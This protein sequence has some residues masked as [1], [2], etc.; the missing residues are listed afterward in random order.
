MLTS[1]FNLAYR[2]ILKNKFY[3]LVNVLS[4][5]VA[6][7]IAIIAYWV[8]QYNQ[9]F[10][11]Y[12]EDGNQILR[13]HQE[14]VDTTKKDTPTIPL[15]Q[16]DKFEYFAKDSSFLSRYQLHYG[17]ASSQ[18]T[19]NNSIIAAVDPTFFD[20]FSFD[21]V[22]PPLSSQ[23]RP[24]WI[25]LSRPMAEKM[26]GTDNPMGQTIQ[27]EIDKG[28][29]AFMVAAVIDD[30]PRNTSLWFDALV[31]FSS[32]DFYNYP[33]PKEYDAVFYRSKTETI[34]SIR[35]PEGLYPISL[36]EIHHIEDNMVESK[37]NGV[38]EGQGVR[39]TV[40]ALLF[41]LLAAFN[42]INTS[43]ASASKRLKEIAI[44]KVVGASRRDLFMQLLIENFMVVL[45]S[46]LTG[47]AFSEFFISIY[48]TWWDSMSIQANF[49][50]TG[51]YLYVVL[52][53]LVVSVLVCLFPALYVSGFS[54]SVIFR[55][56]FLFGFNK[57]ITKLLLVGQFSITAYL[58]FLLSVFVHNYYFQNTFDRGY[59]YTNVVNIRSF[60]LKHYLGMSSALKR[61]FP[62][63]R[64]CGTNHLIGFHHAM[65]NYQLE[66]I[67]EQ[68]ATYRVS[69]NYPDFLEMTLKEG[70]WAQLRHNEVVVN[71]NF[72]E[73]FGQLEEVYYQG[74]NYTIVG[75]VK[76]FSTQNLRKGKGVEPVV[77][78][79]IGAHDY[80]Y[81]S[82]KFDNQSLAEIEKV[83]RFYWT[84]NLKD[85]VFQAFSQE[86]ILDVEKRI[87][88]ILLKLN[89]FLS[90]V[91]VFISMLGIYTLV[92]ISIRKRSVEIGVR[93]AFGAVGVE[94]VQLINF[95]YIYIV[96]FA[97]LLGTGAGY[98]VSDYFLSYIFENYVPINLLSFVLPFL[99]IAC[100][101]FIA[102]FW[103]IRRAMQKQAVHFLKDS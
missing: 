87:N 23:M 57:L 81:L 8:H 40:T 99:L 10:N 30:I 74:K 98:F 72:Y 67:G 86:R 49:N 31:L 41:I 94:I 90:L 66:G 7:G 53:G 28:I 4:L 60:N 45:A 59:R 88:I 21:Y 102:V 17:I 2:L 65:E 16:F 34:P 51:F 43:I 20:I 62:K 71:E 69:Y 22:H 47:I 46:L 80:K 25:I 78:Q 12:F 56:R 91:A 14:A 54:P 33:K 6:I 27:V 11:T 50:D 32:Y 63:I 95:D 19:Y 24:N 93:K 85:R 35:M 58:I 82:V 15:E 101:I 9:G 42:F 75:C 76:N 77:I 55:G 3:I 83:L 68:I 100:I 5:G 70:R 39:T 103:K 37:F 84:K 73:K 92:D 18:T 97:V 36:A 38:I 79:L 1:Y 64:Y 48:N 52:L 44:R 89:A 61:E 96:S 29:Y 26:F 13:L